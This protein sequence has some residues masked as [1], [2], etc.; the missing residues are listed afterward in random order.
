MA[1]SSSPPSLLWFQ[2]SKS[3]PRGLSDTPM[4]NSLLPMKSPP[5]LD[6]GIDQAQASV[7]VTVE[8]RM[9]ISNASREVMSESSPPWHL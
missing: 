3:T 8:E 4:K 5:F 2:R 7:D 6:L 1:R 9:A